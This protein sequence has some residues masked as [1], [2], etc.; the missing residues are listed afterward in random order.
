MLFLRAKRAVLKKSD[1]NVPGSVEAYIDTFPPELRAVLR[2]IRAAIRK[3]A[4]EAVEKV[5]YG[6][7]AYAQDGMLVFFAAFKEHVSF[8]PTASGVE[9]FRYE[10]SSYGTSKGGVRFPLGT[11]VPYALIARIVKFRVRENRA[12]AAAKRKKTKLAIPGPGAY[13]RP[14]RGG[15][16]P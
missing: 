12:R 2:R 16:R 15:R 13:N 6:M 1:R 10:L 5:S 4:P 8:F 14:R 11:R 9:K 7:P 3:A